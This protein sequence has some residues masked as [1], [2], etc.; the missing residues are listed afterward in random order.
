M[1]YLLSDGVM[2]VIGLIVV[3]FV[4]LPAVDEKR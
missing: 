2:K 3:G 4:I 1:C